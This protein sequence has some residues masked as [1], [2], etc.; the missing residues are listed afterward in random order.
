MSDARRIARKEMLEMSRDGRVRWASAIVI[1]LLLVALGAGWRQFTTER[2]MR[3]DARAATRQDWL[4]QTAKNPHSAAHYG[5]YAFKPTL[6]L[7]FV[8]R[9]VDAFVG[10]TAFLEAHRQNDFGAR[11]AQDATSIARFGEWTAAAVLQVLVPLLIVLLGFSAI[12]AE[13]ESGTLR[14]LA[15]AGVAPRAILL[16]KASG[17][18]MVLAIVG[19]P[20]AVLGGTALALSSGA[21]TDI[22]IRA[23]GLTLVYLAYF[24][25]F[26]LIV[27]A[28]S[29]WAQSSRSALVALL[30]FWAANTLLAPRMLAD[31]SRSLRP[32]PSTF[33]FNRD[34]E[35]DL[36]DGASTIAAEVTQRVMTKGDSTEFREANIRGLTLEAGERHGDAVFDRNYATLH[37]SFVAQ[38]HVQQ[39]GAL[40][41]PLTAVRFLSMSLAGTDYEQHWDFAQAAERYRR[42]LVHRMNFAIAFDKSTPADRPVT[43]DSLLWKTVTPFTYELPNA[44]GPLA[45][46]RIAFLVLLLWVAGA[47]AIAFRAIR[48]LTPAMTGGA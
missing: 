31:L 34:L 24:V 7:S 36:A 21:N 8:D 13:R 16:G 6:P 42:M 41:V 39:I 46:G 23:L 22:G 37:R 30:A 35:R 1:A 5:I 33:V 43:G 3:D 17:M 29:A 26:A 32:S 28:A 2:T 18:A 12:T 48:R 10:V 4:S 38:N 11:Q 15:C 45:R 19:L 40:L 25:L 20:A 44:M 27:L 9:G 47:T 14:Q